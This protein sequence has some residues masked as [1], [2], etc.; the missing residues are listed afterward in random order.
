MRQYLPA[1]LVQASNRKAV[2]GYVV[3]AIQELNEECS[4]PILHEVR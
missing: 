3:G 2:L 1:P 4:L